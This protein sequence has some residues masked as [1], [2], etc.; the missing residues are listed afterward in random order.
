[1]KNNLKVISFVGVDKFTDFN[2][3][4]TFKEQPIECEFSVLFSET[5]SGNRYPGYEFCKNY[6]NWAKSNKLIASLH[7]CGDVAINKYLNQDSEM[8]A[9][10]KDAIRIQLN[11]NI[12]SYPD[13]DKLSNEIINVIKKHEH[14]VILQKK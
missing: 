10:C 12:A 7:L 14:I 2:T 5:K 1:M 8:M 6:L 13:Y 9:L 11:I 4:L 3:L